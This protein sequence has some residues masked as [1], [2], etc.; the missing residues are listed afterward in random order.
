MWIPGMPKQDSTALSKYTQTQPTQ[1]NGS[2]AT[3]NGVKRIEAL[4][5]G[6]GGGGGQYGGGSFGGLAVIE[7]P[8]VP[9]ATI[10]WQVGAGGSPGSR[11]GTTTVAVGGMVVAAV[12][13]GGSAT[14]GGAGSLGYFGAAG[15]PY[16]YAGMGNTSGG[17]GGAPPVGRL[18]WTPWQHL[19]GGV[20]GGT[21]GSVPRDYGGTALAAASGFPGF[22]GA[23]NAGPG[24]GFYNGSSGGSYTINPYQVTS[25]AASLAGAGGAFAWCYGNVTAAPGGAGQAL[26]CTGA[27]G[28]FGGGG[29]GATQDGN[30]IAA[31]VYG[32][33]A[34]GN[35]GS[36][37][38]VSVWGMTGFA[39]GNGSTA[40]SSTTTAFNLRA[41]GGGGG[42]MLGAGANATAAS[43][44]SAVSVNGGNGGN[45]G[46]G[47]GGGNNGLSTP[48]N[49]GNGFVCFRFYY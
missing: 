45:G 44:N 21:A 41:S 49:G 12:G 39:G 10:S 23:G 11:G 42:G 15:G 43:E 33:V 22:F 38:G 31:N 35:G 46:G 28:G 24:Q 19:V 8:V 36:M 26:G 27:T 37:A 5:C 1:V 32:S 13:G 30:T 2:M 25:P 40:L 3:P 4:L 7:I 16:G 17:D 18:I 29:G 47:G 9:N 6:G 48:G 14:G 20:I 34:G